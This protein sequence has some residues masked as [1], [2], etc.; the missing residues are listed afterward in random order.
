MNKIIALCILFSITLT[1][2]AFQHDDKDYDKSEYTILR[3]SSKVCTELIEI[4]ST[5]KT[6]VLIPSFEFTWM[7]VDIYSLEGRLIE[8]VKI[9]DASEIIDLDTDEERLYI[10]IV[11]N[12]GYEFSGEITL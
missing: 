1:S 6:L 9:T 4:T 10:S 2:Y 12:Q 8:S 3:P 11:T 5:Y 7:N